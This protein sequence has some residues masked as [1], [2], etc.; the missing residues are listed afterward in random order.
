VYVRIGPFRDY[1][2]EHHHDYSGILNQLT[3]IGSISNR[4]IKKR[5]RSESGNYSSLLACFVIPVKTT[6]PIAVPNAPDDESR[7]IVDFKPKP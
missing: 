2:N 3:A 6:S 1:C 5:M 4:S 7:K